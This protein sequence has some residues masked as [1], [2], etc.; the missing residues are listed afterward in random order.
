MMQ[1]SLLYYHDCIVIE[2]LIL[3]MFGIVNLLVSCEYYNYCH[4]KHHFCENVE[5]GATKN[6][7][8]SRGST[9]EEEE[10]KKIL[11]IWKKI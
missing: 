4:L 11:E 2:T 10:M 7:R 1:H 6:S 5:S 8:D 3:K 9:I